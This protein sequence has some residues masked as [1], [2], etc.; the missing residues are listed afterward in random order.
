M[1]SHKN[2]KTMALNTSTYLTRRLGSDHLWWSS[3]TSGSCIWRTPTYKQCDDWDWRQRLFV[4]TVEK[5]TSSPYMVPSDMNSMARFTKMGFIASMECVEIHLEM[6]E[7]LK[8]KY[9]DAAEKDKFMIVCSNPVIR[10][11][12]I[13]AP[14]TRRQYTHHRTYIEQLEIMSERNLPV[15]PGT[16]SCTSSCLES[17]ELVK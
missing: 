12:S 16:Q 4:K 2:Q 15:I 9:N 17:S 5:Q 1:V 10:C 8:R 13:F 6:S 3:F 7:F 14:S 11:R